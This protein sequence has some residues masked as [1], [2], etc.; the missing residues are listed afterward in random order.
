VA[1]LVLV[2][3][4]RYYMNFHL[5]FFFFLLSSTV[6]AQTELALEPGGQHLRLLD[7][8]ASPLIYQTTGVS[9]GLHFRKEKNNRQLSIRANYMVSIT[10]SAN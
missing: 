5:S 9:F 2:G 1:Q 4:T 7:R 10:W 6:F 3:Q 8:H